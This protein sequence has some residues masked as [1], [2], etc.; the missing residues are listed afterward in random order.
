MT[1]FL[2]IKKT[3]LS[4]SCFGLCT[5]SFATGGFFCRVDD[6][7]I[8]MEVSGTTGRMFFSPLVEPTYVK[9]E[10]KKSLGPVDYKEIKFEQ[11]DIHGYWNSGKFLKLALSKSAFDEEDAVDG[12]GE[13]T[14]LIDASKT[15]DGSIAIGSYKITKTASTLSSPEFKAT[16]SGKISCQMD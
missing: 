6:D 2:R 5:S 13:T 16:Y 4:L 15:N 10:F 1:H 9:I 7:S 11:S 3:I 14:L 8:K 12:A